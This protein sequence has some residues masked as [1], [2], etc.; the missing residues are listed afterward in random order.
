MNLNDW[1]NSLMGVY[2][3]I[4]WE[5]MIVPCYLQTVILIYSLGANFFM[6]YYDYP[7]HTSLQTDTT[8]LARYNL[9]MLTIA[10]LFATAQAFAQ[11][12][13]CPSTTYFLTFLINGFFVYISIVDII[14]LWACS[15]LF[16][17]LKQCEAG[18]IFK[19][20]CCYTCVALFFIGFGQ[21]LDFLVLHY[22]KTNLMAAVYFAYGIFLIR[23]ASN[24]YRNVSK[25]EELRRKNNG[26]SKIR[27]FNALRDM[28][29]SHSRFTIINSL[30]KAIGIFLLMFLRTTSNG[31]FY[32]S[33][34]LFLITSIIFSYPELRL[35]LLRF[36]RITN[37]VF[38]RNWMMPSI[39]SRG[40]T[41][42]TVSPRNFNTS[43]GEVWDVMS[44]VQHGRQRRAFMN[45]VGVSNEQKPD[46]NLEMVDLGDA[47]LHI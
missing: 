46:D 36:L 8:R 31:I 11:E 29:I 44:D 1:G 15:E 20:C 2:K 25:L 13:D 26:H 19:I 30:C 38:G 32:Y 9:N 4:N 18:E 14:L 35:K 21:Y 28:I 5:H 33:L 24:Y 42:G 17:P 12:L 40:V 3:A 27:D 39:Q 43:L 7:N 41:Y 23:I 34:I 6:T 37:T 10:S 16:S 45:S 22:L 47:S